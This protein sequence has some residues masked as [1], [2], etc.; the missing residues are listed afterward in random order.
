MVVC[1]MG[2]GTELVCLASKANHNING[3]WIV[4]TEILPKW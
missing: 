4:A 1:A 3:M 2:V